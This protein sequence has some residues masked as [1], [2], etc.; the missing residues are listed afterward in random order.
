MKQNSLLRVGKVG[1]NL[2]KFES[3]EDMGFKKP[4]P[5]REISKMSLNY[6]KDHMFCKYFNI[7]V[8]TNKF[9]NI[10]TSIK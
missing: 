7:S 2:L 3:E 5:Q 6:I 8:P 9:F 1:L 4:N 10:R